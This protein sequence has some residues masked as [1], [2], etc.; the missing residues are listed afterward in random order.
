VPRPG[1]CLD[2][3]ERGDAQLDRAP[4]RLRREDL[5]EC[6]GDRRQGGALQRHRFPVRERAG[7]VVGVGDDLDEPGGDV[8]LRQRRATAAGDD[9]ARRE[10][11]Q[12]GHLVGEPAQFG[13]QLIR[14]PV[15]GGDRRVGGDLGRSRLVAPHVLAEWDRRFRDHI[16]AMGDE[17]AGH[18][19]E[20]AEQGAQ[21][22]ALDRG[23]GCVRV[24]SERSQP[25]GDG[26]GLL[27]VGVQGAAQRGRHR[28]RTS[29]LPL[30]R[31][32]GAAIRLRTT[33]LTSE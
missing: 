28:L 2:R 29:P 27:P 26:D 4:R 9:G 1:D 11:G 32:P 24:R 17:A 23:R 31:Y 12:R 16:A 6:A 18:Q 15:R 19:D 20:V 22:P 10:F 3:H 25:V 13:E 33:R 30:A 5:G 8:V 7:E 14:G 21:V